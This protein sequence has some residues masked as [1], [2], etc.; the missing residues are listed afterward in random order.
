MF[1]KSSQLKYWTFSGTSELT[2]LR[3][4]TNLTYIKKY[5][6]D[7]EVYIFH[8]LTHIQSFFVLDIVTQGW[9]L[10]VDS[11]QVA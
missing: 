9:G 1:S 11:F 5:G 10:V 8:L 7:Y 3:E 4:E 6:Q 2:Q